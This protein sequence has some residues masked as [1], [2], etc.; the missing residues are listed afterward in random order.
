MNQ[1]NDFKVEISS[2]TIVFTVFFIIGLFVAWELRVVFFMFFIAYIISATFRPAVD[3][4]ESKKFPRILSII[5]LLF[6]SFIVI[7]LLVFSIASEAYT[8][9]NN[10]FSQLPNIVFN[11]ITN[12]N[13]SIPI[14]TMIDAQA[15]KDNLKDIVGLLMKFDLSIFTN[16]ISSALGIL[17]A[18]AT[19]TVAISMISILAIYMLVRRDDVAANFL[20]FLDRD[21]KKK[22]LEIFKKIEYRLGSWLRAQVL[23]M[24]SAGFFTWLGLTIPA[25]FIPDYSLHN[26]ALPI[27]LLVFIIELVPGFGIATGGIL[28]SVIALASGNVFLIIFAPLLFIII[29]QVESMLIVPKVMSKAIDLDPV[30]TILGVVAGSMLF[31]LL[32]VILIIPLIAVLK[33]IV[34]ELIEDKEAASH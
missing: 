18:A 20:I 28:T 15:I 12:I 26:Y 14:S 25:F 33:I 10:L 29:Q 34:V 9:L 21:N 4:L 27:A 32:G 16:G 11:I 8:Q 31:G 24:F 3:F 5:I 23:V 1:K 17:G 22:Y 6:L 30:I 2:K 13:N 19:L 7:G